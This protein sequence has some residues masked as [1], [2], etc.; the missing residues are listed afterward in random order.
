MR[1]S[2]AR[3]Q[4][5][6]AINRFTTRSENGLGRELRDSLKNSAAD[7]GIQLIARC[8]EWR[9][10]NRRSYTGENAL[11]TQSFRRSKRACPGSS[12]S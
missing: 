6:H 12:K 3:Q 5:A 2:L 8:G 4:D 1:E 11:P 7:N 9:T 10:R